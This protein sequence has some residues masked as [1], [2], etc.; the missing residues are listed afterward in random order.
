MGATM[1]LINNM[2]TSLK[3]DY[4]H[5]CENHGGM[6]NRCIRNTAPLKDNFEDNRGGSSPIKRVW[7]ASR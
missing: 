1:T 2:G 4:I 5:S 7:R 6:C 3:C